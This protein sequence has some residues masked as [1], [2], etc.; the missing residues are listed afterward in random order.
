MNLEAVKWKG[1]E[2]INLAQDRNQWDVLVDTVSK[3]L[4]SQDERNYLSS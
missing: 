3:L 2:W 1:V 4:F